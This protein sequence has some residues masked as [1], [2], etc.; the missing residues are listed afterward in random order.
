MIT[1]DMFSPIIMLSGISLLKTS[2]SKAPG[3]FEV[4]KIFQ[5]RI[6]NI[7]SQPFEY[8]VF[9]K[10]TFM[11]PFYSKS[12]TRH[13]IKSLFGRLPAIINHQ[14]AGVQKK[15]KH[16][17]LTLFTKFYMKI[18]IQKRFLKSYL[19]NQIKAFFNSIYYHRHQIPHRGFYLF[20]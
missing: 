20:V 18:K 7:A 19:K 17:S 13:H 8:V 4:R 6:G 3:N 14:L 16:L 1:R 15:Q 5:R 12:D 10:S 11:L 2:G 9:I